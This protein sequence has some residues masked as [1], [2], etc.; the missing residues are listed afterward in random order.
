MFRRSCPVAHFPSAF[1]IAR[2]RSDSLHRL[3]VERPLKMFRSTFSGVQSPA[4][5][6]IPRGRSR[7]ISKCP[8]RDAYTVTLGLP[9]G[10]SEMFSQNLYSVLTCT[11]HLGMKRPPG[12]CF[13]ELCSS[14]VYN[15]SKSSVSKLSSSDF[16]FVAQMVYDLASLQHSVRS[17]TFSW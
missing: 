12:K 2:G 3:D 14:S 10:R 11:K 17:K 4:T 15:V 8:R 6:C 13:E 5:F 7:F 1:C 9:R 16:M